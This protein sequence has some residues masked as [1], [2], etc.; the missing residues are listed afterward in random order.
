[1]WRSSL[2]ADVSPRTAE[3]YRG[4]LIR[5]LD[6]MNISTEQFFEEF[7]SNEAGDDPRRNTMLMNDVKS[8]LYELYLKHSSSHTLTSH[9]AFLHFCRSNALKVDFEDLNTWRRK[10]LKD[11]SSRIPKASKTAI[12]AILD[13]AK[14][15][16]RTSYAKARNVAL[17]HTLKDSGL[18]RSDLILMKVGEVQPA[19][20]AGAQ[21][22]QMDSWRKKT[23]KRQI[24]HLGPESLEAIAAYL[25]E[26]R[27]D[28][29][30]YIDK[31]RSTLPGETLTPEDPLWIFTQDTVNRK[32]NEVVN[33]YGDALTV[34]GVTSIFTGLNRKLPKEH[35]YS[36]HSLRSYNWTALESG[37]VPK[38]WACLTQGRSISD[39][40]SQY[41]LNPD[42]P[43][44]RRKL[45]EAYQQAYREIAVHETPATT[46]ELEKLR[47]EFAT[48]T[49]NIEE[50]DPTGE[51]RLKA[52]QRRQLEQLDELGLTWEQLQA[53]AN[54]I[55]NPPTK[56]PKP[57][58]PQEA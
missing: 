24:P 26:R 55:Q 46:Q 39:S 56:P 23:I 16:G 41:T 49:K 32:T 2:G 54:I 28:K 20:E 37:R 57:Q 8:A 53:I 43:E 6:Q 47:Q 25:D 4:G 31:K 30:K 13:A 14:Q 21:W 51:K 27:K 1:M 44:D 48:L 15:Y 33:V 35:H 45:L 9:K 40:S 29:P 11:K 52:Q 12:L 19:I 22:L 7:E 17:I 36:P 58:Q 42:D 10:M 34:D 5:L 38:N 3:L 18:S 50:I